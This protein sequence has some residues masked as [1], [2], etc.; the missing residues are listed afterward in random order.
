MIDLFPSPNGFS[1]EN[2]FRGGL[3][4][5]ILSLI[6]L[7]SQYALTFDVVCCRLLQTIFQ[8]IH[9]SW[10]I[11]NP[12]MP[13][14]WMHALF[15]ITEHKP[16]IYNSFLFLKDFSFF[17]LLLYVALTSY[18]LVITNDKLWLTCR[19]FLFDLV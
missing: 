13:Y 1:P 11:F 16:V 14:A 17:S 15:F 4:V 8:T 3:F 6:I 10:S 9:F 7:K 2:C 18:H 5:R 19:N 12:S